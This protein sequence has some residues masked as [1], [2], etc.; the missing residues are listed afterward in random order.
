MIKLV[1]ISTSN[2]QFS[3]NDIIYSQIDWRGHEIIVRPNTCYFRIQIAEN[4]SSQAIY[5]RY[6]DD[7]LVISKTEKDNENIFQKFSSLH[8]KIS[9]T[10]EVEENN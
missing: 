5:I 3:F 9:F 4:L 6:V 10:R 7:C 8:Q 1:K 2:L